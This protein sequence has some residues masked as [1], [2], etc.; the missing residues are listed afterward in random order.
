MIAVPFSDRRFLFAVKPVG[1]PVQPDPSGDRD[2]MTALRE[3]GDGPLWLVHRLDRAVGGLV[4]FARDARAAAD[5]CSLI[6]EREVKK[7]YLCVTEV[8]TT[9][10]MPADGELRD[11]LYHDRRQG[12]AFVVDRMRDG[13]KEAALSYH[14]LSRRVYADRPLDLLRVT[15]HTGRFHQ[16]RAQMAHRQTPLFGDG[17]Y[18]ARLKGAVALFSASLSFSLYGR[19]YAAAVYPDTNVLPWYLFSDLPKEMWL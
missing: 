15:L 13:V 3:E 17:K 10:S 18:G 9:E 1:M 19:A 16:I 12:K 5:L 8:H 4:V 11:F 2:L 14:T 6:A 7:T